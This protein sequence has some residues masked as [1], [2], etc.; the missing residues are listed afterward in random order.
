MLRLN[1]EIDEG[2]KAEGFHM[3]VGIG[4]TASFPVKHIRYSDFYIHHAH[5][6]CI[7][8]KQCIHVCNQPTDF[9]YTAEVNMEY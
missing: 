3:S 7:Y 8:P 9:L 2:K 6:F 5:E 1:F 4:P